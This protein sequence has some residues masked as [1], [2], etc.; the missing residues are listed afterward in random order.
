[1][2]VKLVQFDK[3]EIIRKPETQKMEVEFLNF[4]E[5]ELQLPEQ[6]FVPGCYKYTIENG[7]IIGNRSCVVG[8]EVYIDTPNEWS[9]K[10]FLEYVARVKKVHRQ[11][12]SFLNDYCEE[13]GEGTLEI[14]RPYIHIEEEVIFC[15]SVE[16]WNFG[17][18][19]TVLMQKIYFAIRNDASKSILVPICSAWQSDL[20]RKFFPKVRFIYY[21][22]YQVV[23]VARATVI[24]WPGFGF[25]IASDYREYIQK[26]VESSEFDISDER[27]RIWLARREGIYAQR[28]EMTKL[29]NMD[30]LSNGYIPLYPELLP[31]DRTARIVRECHSI[32]LDSGSALFNLIF[33][34]NNVSAN[35]FESRPEFLLN[36]SRFMN[37]CNIKSRVLFVNV[38]SEISTIRRK[39]FDPLKYTGNLN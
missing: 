3:V 23:S 16:F 11:E 38:S 29:I 39:L 31:I 32:I 7:L 12:F 2:K 25:H 19:L 5:K 36:H 35:L 28:F 9:R 20:L 13:T 8:D 22:P 27:K 30:L 34:K 15:G 37:S 21:D 4:T 24:S 10:E 26:I 17:F 33:A 18:F 14:A 6:Y 1:M